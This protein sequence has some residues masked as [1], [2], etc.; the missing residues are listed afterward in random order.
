MYWIVIALSVFTFIS[1]LHF[2]KRLKEMA[3]ILDE[4]DAEYLEKIKTLSEKLNEYRSN[5][6]QLLS[7]RLESLKSDLNY[8]LGDE[9]KQLKLKVS[10]IEKKLGVSVIEYL[11]KEGLSSSS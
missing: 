4:R 6:S 1:H 3:K 10:F 9:V 7:T 5:Q 8:G 2:L 11:E